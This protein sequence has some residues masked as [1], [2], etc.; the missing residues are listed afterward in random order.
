MQNHQNNQVATS[1]PITVP[2]DETKTMLQQLLQ[3]QQLQGKALNQVTTEIN[4]RM[5]HMFRDLSTKYD[6]VASHMRQMDIQIAQTAESV[7]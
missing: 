7:N 2:Q 6:N 3:G 5:N 1:T 4:T